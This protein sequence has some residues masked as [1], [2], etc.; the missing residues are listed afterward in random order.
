MM[1]RTVAPAI[2]PPPPP[3]ARAGDTWTNPADGSVYLFVPGGEYS[4]GSEAEG[5]SPRE[6]PEHSVSVDGFWMQQTETTN[7]QYARCVEEG[8]CAAPDNE[9]W[10][11]ATAYADHPVANVSW[12]QAQAYA[13]W[14]GARLPTEA[15]WE[16]ACRGADHNLYPWGDLPPSPDLSN[17]EDAIQDTVPVGSYPD[18]AASSGALDMAGNVWEWTS[19]LDEVYPYDAADG[20]EDADDDGK[21]IM[22]GGSFYYN[23]LLLR[24]SARTGANASTQIPHLGFRTVLDASGDTWTNP[25]DGSVYHLVPGGEYSIGSEAEGASPREAPEHSVSVD[26]FWMQQTETTNAQYARCVEEGVCDRARQRTLERRQPSP[27]IPSPTSPGSRRRP[28]PTGCGARLPTEAEWEI[29]CRGADHNLYPWGDLPPSPDLSNFEDAIQDTVAVGSYPD[30][31]ASSGAL[32]MAGNVWE[33]TSSLDEVYPYDAADGR[34]DADEDGK[35]I[36][37]GGSFYY[38]ALL[39]RCSARTGANAS[40][41]IP[42]LGFRTVLDGE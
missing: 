42:H 12:Q 19:S 20:R 33:W 1:T 21:R 16:I 38:N 39:L 24:C 2:L 4:I 13:A 22:R 9:R 40:T 25:A 29:A 41:Q 27:T 23:A 15:E 11:D 36:M 37:R 6:A 31:A 8:V 26:G 3:D 28:T 35:R 17:F 10:N 30:G 7:A 18:G 14:M 32:D 34:E 5:A